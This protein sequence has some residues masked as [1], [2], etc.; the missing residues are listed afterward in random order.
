M[1]IEFVVPHGEFNR[2]VKY[3]LAGRAT[4]P[5][6]R[7]E[8]TDINLKDAEL[9]FVSSGVSSS[10]PV[11]VRTPGY[12]RVPFR[13]FERISRAI[14][15]LRKHSLRVRIETGS[16]KVEN[17]VFS[18]PEISL[19]LI[20]ARIADLPIDASLP[21]ILALL[22]QFRP[23]EINDSGLLGKVPAAQ[24]EASKLIDQAS[25]V[26]EPL[27]LERAAVSHFVTEQI[28][29]RARGRKLR[30]LSRTSQLGRSSC[31]GYYAHG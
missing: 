29:R 23:E 14:R 18:H 24:E 3:L 26:L 15:T 27:G 31:R 6:D 7:L 4:A 11:D 20:G 2:A 22:A 8:F 30:N 19:R 13:V 5:T 25:A 10:L 28:E 12:A 21:D 16:I 1:S 9:E 17:S